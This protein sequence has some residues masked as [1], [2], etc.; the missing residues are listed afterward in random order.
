MSSIGEITIGR[1]VIGPSYGDEDD[2]IGIFCHENGEGGDFDKAEF[3]QLIEKFYRE[4]F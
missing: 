4:S 1:F 2:K 3:E